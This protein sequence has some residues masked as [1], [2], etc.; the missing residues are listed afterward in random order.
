M[1]HALKYYKIFKYVQQAM[2]SSFGGGISRAKP[3]LPIAQILQTAP[4]LVLRCLCK[5][6]WGI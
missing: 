4:G 5:A 6:H 2:H 3:G 1:R